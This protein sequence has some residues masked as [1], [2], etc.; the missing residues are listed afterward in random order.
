MIAKDRFTLVYTMA[1]AMARTVSGRGHAGRCRIE[2][3]VMIFDI[4]WDVHF[5]QGKGTVAPK[6]YT[7]NAKVTTGGDGADAGVRQR[8]IAGLQARRIAG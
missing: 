5:V 1:G 7:A 2:N 4:D 8:R 6:P 3:G